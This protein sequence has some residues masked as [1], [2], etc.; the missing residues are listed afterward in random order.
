MNSTSDQLFARATFTGNQNGN[1]CQ[2][3]L[4]DP[5]FEQLHGRALP[6]KQLVSALK[7][8]APLSNDRSLMQ[9]ASNYRLKLINIKGLLDVVESTMPHRF[10][11]RRY[12]T[13][14][15]HHDGL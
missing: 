1:V 6:D 2:R 7:N 14:S 5:P 4:F 10:N 13:V 11:G 8:F 15:C 12:G 9:S 3:D